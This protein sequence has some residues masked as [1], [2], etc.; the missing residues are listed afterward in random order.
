[1]GKTQKKKLK[2][3]AKDVYWI[4]P[5]NLKIEMFWGGLND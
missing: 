2:N 4:G 5:K 1:M 3:R